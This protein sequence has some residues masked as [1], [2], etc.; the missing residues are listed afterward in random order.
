MTLSRPARAF[1]FDCYGT[2][3]D[4][5][6]GIHAALQAIPALDG[7]DLDAFVL[8]RERIEMEIEAGAY[9]PYETVL[10]RSLQQTAEAFGGCVSDSEAREF[11][12]S[13]PNWPAF[14]DASSFLRRLRA[15]DKP[16]LILSNIT[17]AI[18]RQSI[19]KLEVPFDALV[20]AEDVRSYK[21]AAAHWTE[22]LAR[23]GLRST[24]LLHIAASPYHDIEP[25][26]R[27]G[28]PCVWVNRRDVS[29]PL[30]A[31]AALTVPGLEALAASLD[32][33]PASEVAANPRER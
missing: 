10:A 2:L 30:A 7:L 19:R 15:L 13:V 4:W 22:A 18:L 17:N 23:L 25:A 11:A 26:A 31:G 33:P 3:I 9:L 14:S 29:S 32:L 6:A 21:P 1:T 27:L 12:T 16:L 8:R 5:D 20:T 28:I 24:D